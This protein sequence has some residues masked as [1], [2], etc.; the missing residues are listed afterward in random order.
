MDDPYRRF[1][2]TH[3]WRHLHVLYRTLI[4]EGVLGNLALAPRRRDWRETLL[5]H[6]NATKTRLVELF[7]LG[8]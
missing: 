1:T 8:L 3:R 2:I 7:S 6:D 5:Q 4:T